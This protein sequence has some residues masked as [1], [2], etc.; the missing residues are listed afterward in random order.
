MSTKRPLSYLHELNEFYHSRVSKKMATSEIALLLALYQINNAEDWL[1]WFEADNAKLERLTGLTRE[2]VRVT[3]NKLKQKGRIDFRIGERNTRPPQYSIIPFHVNSPDMNV[4]MNVGMN[5]AH[6][7]RLRRNTENTD[8]FSSSEPSPDSD[9]TIAGDTPK[10]R[11]K[12]EKPHFA[13]DSIPY[14]SALYLA[15]K[16][17]SRMENYPPLQE[18]KRTETIQR[19]ALD[20]DR[21]L[22]IDKADRDKL[23][24]VLQF[25]QTDPFWRGNVLSGDALRRFYYRLVS[26]MGGAE[27]GDE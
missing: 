17:E 20:I 14:K 5:V 24:D 16:I 13:E 22:R 2:G 8:V 21:L 18:A 11:T 3:R 1:L 4:G 7:R 10:K 26:A 23:R 19:W 15:K 9:G 6:L 27:G 25:S 12:R